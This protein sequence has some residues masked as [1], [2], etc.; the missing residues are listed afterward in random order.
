MIIKQSNLWLRPY[1]LLILIL[2]AY[3]TLGAG[4]SISVP[5]FEAP[6]E[7]GH[8]YYIKYLAE[9]RRLPVQSFQYSENVVKEG[10]QP[11]LYYL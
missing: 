5:I 1:F 8:F 10:H 2:L 11:P 7:P 4:Y 9:E 3:I 6:D